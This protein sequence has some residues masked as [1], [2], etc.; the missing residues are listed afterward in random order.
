QRLQPLLLGAGVADQLLGAVLGNG[1]CRDGGC[2][3]RRIFCALLQLLTE[4][5]RATELTI[6]CSG[7]GVD[8]E[9][10]E[11]EPT[12]IGCGECRE[13][14]RGGIGP[15]DWTRRKEEKEGQKR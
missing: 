9:R 7:G 8:T 1:N 3:R 10:H 2:E 13:A 12:Q 11:V 6:P 14:R 4:E 5:P 15:S